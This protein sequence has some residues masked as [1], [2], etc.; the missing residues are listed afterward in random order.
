MDRITS[1]PLDNH[2]LLSDN[3]TSLFTRTTWSTGARYGRRLDE[4]QLLSYRDKVVSGVHGNRSRLSPGALVIDGGW[5][6]DEG[7]VDFAWDRLIGWSRGFSG[8]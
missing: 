7:N 3:E 4:N 2:R 1:R 5:E 6:T 8:V